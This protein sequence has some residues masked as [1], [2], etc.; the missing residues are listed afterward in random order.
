MLEN[1]ILLLIIHYTYSRDR[2]IEIIILFIHNF[3][4]KVKA[5][6]EIIH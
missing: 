3:S 1:D 6:Y 5:I 4:Y 2:F